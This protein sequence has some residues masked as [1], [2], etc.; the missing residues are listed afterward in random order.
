MIFFISAVSKKC[1]TSLPRCEVRSGIG[2]VL[3]E[4]DKSHY[5][6]RRVQVQNIAVW[7]NPVRLVIPCKEAKYL[8]VPK[9]CDNNN[10]SGS[11]FEHFYK[12]QPSPRPCTLCFFI[13]KNP[14]FSCWFLAWC[15]TC[16]Q[17]NF[18]VDFK[19]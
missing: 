9:C 10:V 1:A 5:T 2:N 3:V 4:N 15:F 8:T 17:T 12:I 6:R 19:L 16:P 18:V 14:L 11:Q 7:L 13:P